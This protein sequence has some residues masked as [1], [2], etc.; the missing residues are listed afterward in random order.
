[1]RT[2][3]LISATADASIRELSLDETEIVGGGRF[4]WSKL[5]SSVTNDAFDGMVYGA[6]GGALTGGVPGATLGA[7][8]GIVGGVIVGTKD[9]LS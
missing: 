8:G 3:T 7:I 9:G 5:A 6:T 4:S 2:Q 1:M